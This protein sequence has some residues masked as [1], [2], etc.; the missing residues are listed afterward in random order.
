MLVTDDRTSFWKFTPV[1]AIG[2]VV[3]VAAAPVLA[4]PEVV[5]SA[6]RAQ[7]VL[8][9]VLITLALACALVANTGKFAQVVWIFALLVVM[10]WSRAPNAQQE[11]IFASGP[12]FDSLQYLANVSLRGEALQ[13]LAG[14]A[15]GLLAMSVVFVFAT[16]QERLILTAALFALASLGI[17]VAGLIG[18]SPDLLAKRFAKFLVLD[19]ADVLPHVNL[20][21]PVAAHAGWI[22]PNALGATALM[23]LPVNLALAMIPAPPSRWRTAVRTVGWLASAAA[24]FVVVLTQ[25]RSVWLAATIVLATCVV[26]RVHRR[27][28][29]TAAM[30]VALSAAVAFALWLGGGSARLDQAVVAASESASSR[31]ILWR[32]AIERFAEAPWLGIGLNQLHVMPSD[33]PVPNTPLIVSHAHN[34]ILQVALDLGLLGLVCY[35]VLQVLLLVRAAAAARD[36]SNA[37]AVLA[38][39]A[40]L[41]LVGVHVFG[42]ADT[43]ALGARVGLFQ[44]LSSGIVLAAWRLQRDAHGGRHTPAPAARPRG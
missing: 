43:V 33:I 7:V 32:F 40:A 4:F 29:R 42:I 9:V 44:W 2:A 13:H 25:S 6:M 15:L 12:A 18:T 24:V 28:A 1:Q 16:S 31:V 5:P 30:V 3:L 37:A 41:S 38:V 39:G 19:F 23:V 20:G 35:V 21:L 34:T 14:I 17:V 8:G 26:W 36:S 11:A 27:W 22:N 10:A